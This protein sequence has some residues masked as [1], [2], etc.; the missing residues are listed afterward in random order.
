MQRDMTITNITIYKQ[1]SY[2]DAYA[3]HACGVT[4]DAAM[5]SDV[6]WEGAT[7]CELLCCAVLFC[8]E[9]I[10]EDYVRHF[11]FIWFI[12]RRALPCS[13]PTPGA[14]VCLTYMNEWTAPPLTTVRDRAGRVGDHN[15]AWYL[16]VYI[17][18]KIDTFDSY[19]QWCGR[20][21]AHGFNCLFYYMMC[22]A[23][24]LCQLRARHHIHH[25]NLLTVSRL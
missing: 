25:N 2:Q 6:Q 1:S 4:L 24:C 21:A 13:S 14:G 18:H 5:C 10:I 17:T 3:T 15:S 9:W 20:C 11:N 16:I 8:N 19:G 22:L 12:Y 23:A 7:A